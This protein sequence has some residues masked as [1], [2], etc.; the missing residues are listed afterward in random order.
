[1]QLSI[2]G[3]TTNVNYMPH[4]RDMVTIKEGTPYTVPTGKIFVLT[5]LGTTVLNEELSTP[6]VFT[7]DGVTEQRGGTYGPAS[8]TVVGGSRFYHDVCTGAPTPPGM[9]YAAGVVLAVTGGAA[10]GTD[11]RAWGYIAPV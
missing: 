1:M 3:V 6:V 2:I 4:P 8:A 7:A 10:S 5:G 9:T 11:G